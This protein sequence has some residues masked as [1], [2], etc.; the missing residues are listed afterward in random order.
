M[1]DEVW[2]SRSLSKKTI[3][4]AGAILVTYDL[5]KFSK[6]VQ[7]ALAIS[8]QT[9]LTK[10]ALEL[11]V[12]RH[13]LEKAVRTTTGKSFGHLRQQAL[14]ETAT[15]LLQR[16]PALAIKDIAA[17]M[18]FSSHQAFHHFTRRA[19][20]KTPAQI[21]KAASTKIPDKKLH[22]RH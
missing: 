11:A 19:S 5:A 13:T 3:V 1:F 4:S 20:G 12:D 10:L 2:N 14:L 6:R 8:P 9:K 18:G 7:E 17:R 22:K 15:E 21:R 16:E